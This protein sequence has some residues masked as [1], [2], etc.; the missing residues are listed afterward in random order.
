MLQYLTVFVNIDFILILICENIYNY[1]EFL[2]IM[3]VYCETII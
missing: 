3:L 2:N 1:F